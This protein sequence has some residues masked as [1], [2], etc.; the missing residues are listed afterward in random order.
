MNLVE[1]GHGGDGLEVYNQ[2]TRPV[3]IV[4][5]AETISDVGD[6]FGLDA[7][8]EH[9]ENPREEDEEHKMEMENDRFMDLLGEQRQT[10]EEGVRGI[11]STLDDRS[12]VVEAHEDRFLPGVL[13][14]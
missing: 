11:L 7:D 5:L 6:E 8:V 1:K 2:V 3:A 4:E 13:Q 14:D 9:F 12:D 10:L